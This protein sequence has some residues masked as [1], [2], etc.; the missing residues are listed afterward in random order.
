MY[1]IFCD[2]PDSGDP[3]ELATAHDLTDAERVRDDYTGRPGIPGIP[4]IAP[5]E[6]R[7]RTTMQ[8]TLVELDRVH[9]EVKGVH[10]E[11]KAEII[12][13]RAGSRRLF[14]STVTA[15]Q[16][17]GAGVLGRRSIV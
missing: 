12:G 5:S 6:T 1:G 8:T 9:A 14:A 13:V 10:A 16:Q 17:V 11:V 3:I 7:G 15:F 4:F 2:D